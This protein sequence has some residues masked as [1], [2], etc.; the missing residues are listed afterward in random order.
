MCGIAG[1]FLRHGTP[2]SARLQ[3]AAAA[4]AHRG[5]DDT[6]VYVSGRAGLVHTRLSIIDLEGGHQPIRSA[7]EQLSLIVNGEI[8]NY[9]ELSDELVAEGRRFETRSDS[10]TILHAY[11]VHG[12]DF[13][14][15]L[16][17]MFAFALLDAARET[18]L[19]GRDRLGIKPLFYARTPDRFVFASE[20]KALLP[21]LPFQPEIN[22]RALVEYLQNQFN[23]GEETIFDG[24]HRV[25]PGTWL[26]VDPD[27]NIA[28][29]RYWSALD[30]TPRDTAPE[31]ADT[32]FEALF[33][34]VM[35]E[36]MRSDV[37]FGLF[38]SGGLDSGVLLA[39][40]RE[41]STAPLKTY[42]VGFAGPGLDDELEQARWIAGQF[43]VEHI[44][45]VLS[46]D[47]I[48]GHLVHTVW[49]ADD[50]M[51]DYASLA[52]SLLAQ[53]AAQDLKVV[54]SGEGGDE[55]FGGYRRYR[56]SL[57]RRLKAL[58]R[59]GSGGFRTRGHW[60]GSRA[61][62]IFGTRLRPLLPLARQPFTNA[63]GETP[64]A[65]SSLQRAQY[66]DLVT[67]LPDNLLVKA[68]RM[69]MSFSL[70][71][72]VPF[73][74][75][76][77]VDFG[78]SLPD[79][80]KVSGRAGKVFLKHWAERRIPRDYLYRAKRGFHVPVGHWLRGDFL[81]RLGEKLP[82]NRAIRDWFDPAGVRRLVA[83][84][85]R[86]GNAGR[87]LWGILQFAVWHRLFIE[88]PADRPSAREDLLDWI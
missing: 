35:T 71:G 65:W 12:D 58:I 2:D 53:R 25:P 17:G 13:A 63:W 26:R 11:A 87:E 23:T 60:R 64:P 62:R 78:L 49:A 29:H 43:G 47:E 77:V 44:P 46:G 20:L 14:R 22:P 70:E 39:K 30:V 81:A 18:L 7:T 86:R 57:E 38:L 83:E 10:E 19:V 45:L 4:L 31:E 24:I 27:L 61:R 56:Q 48:F 52:T 8:Y 3:A 66:T 72:R 73:L 33:D 37:P 55:V 75:H 76:R 74:D 40:L 82:E 51:R 9:R 68:D 41:H 88:G 6:G 50:L 16:H 79:G 21:L 1:I 67:A 69:L 80:M 54:F 84:Q 15:H 42:S 85:D 36:H 28:S 34:Q 5:P 32:E 59:P